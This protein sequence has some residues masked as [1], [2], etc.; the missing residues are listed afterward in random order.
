MILKC[1]K[2]R[3]F[4]IFFA[5]IILLTSLPLFLIIILVLKFT[6]DG[7]IF[8]IQKR[9]GQNGKIFKLYKFATMAKNTEQLKLSIP[10]DRWSSLIFP[11]GKLLRKTKFNELPQLC[12]VLLGDMSF[13]GPRPLVNSTLSKYDDKFKSSILLLKP[14]L[15]GLGSLVFRNE[16][17]IV[18]LEN[19]G[20]YEH[21][22]IP[23]KASLEFWYS[24]NLSF[25]NDC[26]VLL[27]TLVILFYP[28]FRLVFKWF[29]LIPPLPR[30]LA[31]HIL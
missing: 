31:K 19:N 24:K 5:I 18:S 3:I 12:N 20:F 6:G 21:V 9:V 28:N 16:E 4:D 15:S 13:I 11:F 29:P 23:Y 26:K 10:K 2:K 25:T 17:D 14:G 30:K 7:E 27:L 1:S 22:I 8:F